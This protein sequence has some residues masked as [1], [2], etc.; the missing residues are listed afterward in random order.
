MYVIHS[1][2]TE[3]IWVNSIIIFTCFDSSNQQKL[4]LPHAEVAVMSFIICLLLK[5][6]IE[7][8]KYMYNVMLYIYIYM[9]YSRGQKSTCISQE[10]FPNNEKWT[11]GI[12][13]N[14]KW[15]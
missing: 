10:D 13:P 9:S 8:N 4:Q 11:R 3:S 5:Y 1:T 7:W 2:M 12:Y 14:E 15:Y 6:V